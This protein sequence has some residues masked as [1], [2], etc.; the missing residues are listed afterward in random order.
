[1][2]VCDSCVSNLG[3]HLKCFNSAYGFRSRNIKWSKQKEEITNDSINILT[4]REFK[5]CE[6]HFE[7]L[8]FET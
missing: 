8:A 3:P 7:N 1:M 5:C 2:N 4:S 6:L